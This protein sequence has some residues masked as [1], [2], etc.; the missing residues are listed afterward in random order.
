MAGTA[1]ND[2]LYNAQPLDVNAVLAT[3][4]DED[5]TTAATGID[6]LAGNDSIAAAANVVANA[7]STMNAPYVPFRL[8]GTTAASSSKGLLGGDGADLLLNLASIFPTALSHAE[9]MEVILQ[10]DVGATDF[11]TA[12]TSQAIGIEGG[13]GP[14][15]I[16]STGA[17]SAGAT[18]QTLVKEARISAVEV[19]LESY[20][21]GDATTSAK[22]VAVGILGDTLTGTSAVTPGAI[23]IIT[24]H[25]SLSA[26]ASATSATEQGMVELIGAAR[27]DDSTTA[28][29]SA[30]GIVGG[31]NDNRITNYHTIYSEAVSSA[32]M[33]SVEI[34]MKGFMLKPAFDLFGLDVGTFQTVADS[35]AVGI[36]GNAGDDT[37]I[38]AG[39]GGTGEIEVYARAE[40]DSEIYTFSVSPPLGGG[41]GQAAGALVASGL[42]LPQ[43]VAATGDDSA[44][45]YGDAST[46]AT[47]YTA[48]ILAGAG[49]DTVTNDTFLT[50]RAESEASNLTLSVDVALSKTSLLPLPGAAVADASTRAVAASRG[51]DGG[52][53]DDVIT[54]S[55]AVTASATADAD[56]L[57][58]AATIKGSMEGLSAGVSVTDASSTAAATSKG[59][60]G[61]AGGDTITNTG[62]VTSTAS[63]SDNSTSVSATLAG[64]K[65]GVAVGVTVADAVSRATA[66]SVG[67]DAEDTGGNE[68]TSTTEQN[69]VITNE[70]LIQSTAGSTSHGDAVGVS[71]AASLQGVSVSVAVTE[72]DVASE[73]YATGVRSGIGQDTIE[74]RGPS[75]AGIHATA[76]A[77]SSSDSVSVAVSG[78]WIGVA[79]GAS[80]AEANTEANS[81]AVG[82]E[83]GDS[84]DVVT[85]A[86]QIVTSSTATA[87]STAVSVT[88]AL[89]PKGFSAGVAMAETRTDSA[90]DAT[91]IDAGDGDD[92]ID[93]TGVVATSSTATTTTKTVTVNF[94]EAG[95]AVADVSSQARASA[96]GIEGGA[97]TDVLTNS[98]SV[99]TTAT[100]TADDTSGTAN[101]LGYARADIA[102]T[103]TAMAI[104]MRGEALTNTSG[105][106]I[107]TTATANAYADNYVVQGGGVEF[108]KVGSQADA[109][110]TGMAGTALADTISN[111]GTISSIANSEIMAS[112]FSFNL[113]GA[114]LG[115]VGVNATGTAVGIDAGDGANTIIND[116]NGQISTFADLSTTSVD[117]EV[118]ILSAQFIRSGVTADAW[119]HGILAGADDDTIHNRGSI[120]ATANAL[121]EAGGASLGLM[122]MSLVGALAS[123]DI[124]GIHS[125][126]GDDAITNTGT[127][128]AGAIRTG[129]N[130]LA[131]AETAAVSFDLFSLVMSS[132]GA[133]ADVTG[134]RAGDGDDTVSNYGTIF[135]GDEGDDD[136]CTAS[137]AMVIGRSLS[138]GGQIL[139]ATM[140]F[141][142]SSARIASVGIDGGAGD[143]VLTNYEEGNI[144]VKAR[145]YADV[146][147]VTYQT[148]GLLDTFA[149]ANAFSEAQATGIYGGDGNDV[150]TNYGAVT[151]DALTVAD[152]ESYADVGLGSNPHGVSEAEATAHAAGIDGGAQGSKEIH[153]FGQ[154]TAVANAGARPRARS[155]SGTMNTYAKGYGLAD[156]HAFGITS[157]GWHNLVTNHETGSISVTALAGTYDTLGNTGY[158]NCD[159]IA[160]SGA[161]YAWAPLKADG[162]GIA[163]AD[164][165]DIV[166]NDGSITVFSH[167][168]GSIYTHTLNRSAVNAN[169]DSDARSYVLG[170]ATGIAAGAG[171]NEVTNN[172]LLTVEASSYAAPK[173]YSW[174]AFVSSSADAYGVSDAVA[175]GL[176]ADGAITNSLSGVLDVT[177]KARSWANAPTESE[178]ATA[179]ALLTAEATGFGTFTDDAS[180][181]LQRIINH[182]TATVRALAGEEDGNYCANVHSKLTSGA[183]TANS[184]G[185]L[186]VDA[187]GVRVGDGAKEIINT[188][189]LHVLGKE[190]YR[191]A[192]ATAVSRY[193]NATANSHGTGIATAAGVLAASGDNRVY[194]SGT[195]DVQTDIN[196]YARSWSDSDWKTT[197]ATAVARAEAAAQGIRVG[198]GDDEIV[199]TGS[200]TVASTA[201]ATSYARSDEYATSTAT[202]EAV[203]IGIDGGSG[204]NTIVNEGDM[205]ISAAAWVFVSAAGDYPTR[206]PDATAR[207][208]GITAGHDGSYILNSGT[209]EVQTSEYENLLVS[210]QGLA[211]GILGGD[212]DDVIVN[213]GSIVTRT[214]G[215][216]LASGSGL[217]VDAGAG[218]DTVVLADGS[219]VIGDVLLGLGDDTLVLAGRPV[220]DG[221]IRAGDD[222]DTL[223]LDG[224]GWF[225]HHLEGFDRVM[226][227]GPGTYTVSGLSP[228]TRLD[229]RE[230]TLEIDGDYQFA[231]AGLLT[232]VARPDGSGG[233]LKI[234]GTGALDGTLAVEREQGLYQPATYDIVAAE[235][236]SGSFTDVLLPESSLLLE[237]SME[238]TADHVQ[239]SVTPHSYASAASNEVEASTG[240]YLDRI[241]PQATG[242]LANTLG[243]FQTLSP[244]EFGAAFASLSPA[245]YDSAATTTFN[246]T[247]QYNQTL[248]KRMHSTRS[249]IESTDGSLAYSQTERH[250][251]WMDGFGN[252]A[253][254]DSQDG[255]AGY[256]YRLAGA[257][258]GA[259]R[260]MADDLL[261]G[262]SYGQSQADIDMQNNLGK[263]DID[264]YFGSLYGS[265]FTDRMYVDATLSY[266]R[267]RYRSTRRIEVGA[268]NGAAHSSHD[269][270]VYSAHGETG[271]NLHLHRWTLQPFAA[272]RYTFLD[273][274]SYA[275]SGAEGVNLRVNDRKTDALTSNLGLRFA[276]H[277]EKDDWLCIPEATIAW[278]HDFDLDDRRIT[279]AFEGAP[280]T[281]FVT[282]G[283]P[284]DRDGVVLG[285]AL[286]VIRKNNLS[287]SLRYTGELR[288]HSRAHALTGGIRY[289]F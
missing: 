29:A 259:D 168:D 20:A 248:F 28:S 125:G 31:S 131:K 35:L 7:S 258:L 76:T 96:T 181:E 112:N 22:S 108:A 174:S 82:V 65:I 212:G 278:D 160:V 228:A 271:W 213:E 133:G 218:D 166:I 81:G 187:A 195:M 230:G 103:S 78:G 64:D 192:N 164:G 60:V 217:A 206:T 123:A 10:L 111:D 200:L 27:V 268:L 12:S 53:G 178:S 223:V 118:G 252:W 32:D 21:F 106:S 144:T 269:G 113:V 183:A 47:S 141:A 263:G 147:S 155:D 87:S 40:A 89:A 90:A 75:S 68:S 227:Q 216:L 203:A 180:T 122:S 49:D 119:S 282:D 198:D 153:N 232:T 245:V 33:T 196:I 6:G 5:V 281:T 201:R 17:L 77:T 236:L 73:A 129:D 197:Y 43:V 63:A 110:A 173:A 84:N 172:G 48:G 264:S 23:E 288:S 224:A 19:P 255:F 91:G 152:A 61:G 135:I 57:G 280:A 244:N 150:I 99:V 167:V 97:G 83:A 231:E 116:A 143:D 170:Q 254:Q 51:I 102:S 85:N 11:S 186:T 117:T 37:I 266:G 88:A 80:Y 225:G 270:D 56:S 191:L 134:I 289:E 205:H 253:R 275:E 15:H 34:K 276:C 220:V 42:A 272:L 98:G 233:Q 214:G 251:V 202:S 107:A 257:A 8:G 137:R 171:A 59:I 2:I 159:E 142:G 4:S 70:G 188:G 204:A 9:I 182:G 58:I 54:N 138:Y 140:A 154:V 210:G 283:R 71:I 157:Q 247:T 14:D 273:E 162:V 284:I 229:L 193:N 1:G 92:T 215:S 179:T 105:A 36:A 120:D 175:V 209:L 207:A 146:D 261:V 267:Q 104:G 130:Y 72:A 243:T 30:A 100:S 46:V 121:G 184:T 95:A 177:A 136:A 194:N 109:R 241:A 256:D 176:E 13:A 277:F 260:L 221:L 44:P 226:K 262:V 26:V 18:S 246:A 101:L 274:Q 190:D 219:S 41:G 79:M 238:Q 86:S 148:L 115:S 39:S 222:T 169:P 285:G 237:F 250:A 69:D 161:G 3:S 234:G 158:V 16:E 239:V 114:Q 165:N 145:S 189:T 127:I 163:L 235:A 151:A 265:Y 242:N 124:S 67:I 249:H 38:N 93:N 208:I 62:V 139:G 128:R 25:G 211:I 55:A 126:G 156:S 185:T 286:T 199:N 279:A 287:L 74:N 66:Y 240:D 149:E 50:S 24:N 94:A 45:A 132:L 52:D